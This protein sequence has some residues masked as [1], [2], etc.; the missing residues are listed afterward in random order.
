MELEMWICVCV[1]VRMQY[2]TDI[3]DLVSIAIA[4]VGPLCKHWNIY[5]RA[6]TEREGRG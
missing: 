6:E 5:V 3:S 1:S 4:I 2:N